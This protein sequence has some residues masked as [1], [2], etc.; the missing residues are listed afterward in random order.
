M[1]VPTLISSSEA[2]TMAVIRALSASFMFTVPPS[3]ALTIRLEPSTFSMVP[4]IRTG[5]GPLIGTWAAARD[6]AKSKAMALAPTV[7]RVIICTVVLPWVANSNQRRALWRLR[8]KTRSRLRYSNRPVG[9]PRFAEGARGSPCYS[10]PVVNSDHQN[11]ALGKNAQ[12]CLI[13]IQLRSIRVTCETPLAQCRHK[14]W[15]DRFGQ[16][17]NLS[18]TRPIILPL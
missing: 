13:C 2:L 7:L 18:N 12:Q 4:R 15:A 5:G 17:G 16:R 11:F 10:I 3:R 8:F 6:T 1:K 9:Y 14:A